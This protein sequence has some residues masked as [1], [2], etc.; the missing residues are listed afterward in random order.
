MKPID[1]HAMIAR[2]EGLRLKGVVDQG[3]FNIVRE[4]V[5]MEPQIDM[6]PVIHCANCSKSRRLIDHKPYDGDPAGWNCIEWDNNF[7]GPHYKADEYFCADAERRD[8]H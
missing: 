1:G 4:A 3:Y 2:V 6:E 8:D 7:Y 5:Q